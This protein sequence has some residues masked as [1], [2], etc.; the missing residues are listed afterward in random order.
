M[1]ENNETPNNPNS[2][3]QSRPESNGIPI[4]SYN[5]IQGNSSKYYKRNNN[6]NP[7]TEH[8]SH[9][10][11]QSFAAVESSLNHKSPLKESDEQRVDDIIPYASRIKKPLSDFQ[12]KKSQK[13]SKQK[14]SEQWR[15]KNNRKEYENY[16]DNR[17]YPMHDKYGF[18]TI[19]IPKLRTERTGVER[20]ETSNN[21][22]L[23]DSTNDS[24][25]V[26]VI[27]ST[28]NESSGSILTNDITIIKPDLEYDSDASEDSGDLKKLEMMTAIDFNR[29]RYARFEIHESE[30]KDYVRT[31]TYKNCL[32][33]CSEHY[34]KVNINY[35]AYTFIGTS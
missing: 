5:Y 22:S 8:K 24:T 34:I 31:I 9:H 23:L 29:D 32:E 13:K 26:P 35:L 28:N 17:Y 15:L 1:Q 14:H 20:N 3:Q 30:M 25:T 33:Y 7:Y 27:M 11:S 6:D 10:Q 18:Q 19:E 16:R 2:W 4:E 12:K 21:P